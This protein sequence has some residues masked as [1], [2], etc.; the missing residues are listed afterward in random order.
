MSKYIE[1]LKEIIEGPI[2]NQAV[3]IPPT[4]VAEEHIDP[5]KDCRRFGVGFYLSEDKKTLIELR[6]Y[7]P[8]NIVVKRRRQGER[9]M[10][11]DLSDPK[12]V[13]KIAQA[14]LGV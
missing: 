13:K 7:A 14:Q 3:L 12:R 6:F 4:E 11:S 2:E 10:T 5:A 8:D 1:G 9:G